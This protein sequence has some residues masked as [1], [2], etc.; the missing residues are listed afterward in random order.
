F[1]VLEGFWSDAGTFESLF[2]ASE[3]IHRCVNYEES[4]N[5]F[6]QL[7]VTES[8]GQAKSSE[9]LGGV[10]GVKRRHVQG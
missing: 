4:E 9:I 3:M 1:S 7:T 8:E 10:T 6:G 2:R 5:Q